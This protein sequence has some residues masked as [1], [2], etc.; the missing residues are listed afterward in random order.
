MKVGIGYDV[1]PFATDETRPLVLG[2]V[3]IEGH[4][5]LA[6]HSDAD[7]VAHSIADAMLGAA[8]L[9]D[10]GAHFSE[11]DE[12]W[13]G[14]DSLGLLAHVAELVKKEGLALVNADCTIVS[15]R[16]RIAGVR[17]EMMEALSAAAA[18][19]VHVKATRPEG[20]GALGRHEGIACMSVVLLGDA[21]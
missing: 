2:G 19:P 9:G 16:P 21:R 8:G 12:R 15:E 11:E 10:L 3:Q 13:Q 20:L 14:A 6:G 5:G 18:G 17:Q 1:H 7:V 4:V